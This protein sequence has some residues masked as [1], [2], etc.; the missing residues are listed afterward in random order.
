MIWK[1]MGYESVLPHT[2]GRIHILLTAIIDQTLYYY[3]KNSFA[4]PFNPLR[5]SVLLVFGEVECDKIT[6]I[7]TTGGKM[8]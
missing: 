5:I 4:V 7:Q 3:F 8:P 2:A 6:F 1:S